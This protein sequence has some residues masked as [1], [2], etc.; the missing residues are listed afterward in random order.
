MSPMTAIGSGA[1]RSRTKSHSPRSQT[2][3]INASHS[4]LIDSSLSFTRFRVNPA[5]TSLRR[6]TC[7]GS[8][9]SIIIGMAGWSG[10]IPPALENNSG[11]RSASITA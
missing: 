5:L 9:M 4:A 1:A 8:S 3:S 10:R 2:E 7:A 6:N 11:W